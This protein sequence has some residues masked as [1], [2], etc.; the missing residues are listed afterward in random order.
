MC[1]STGAALSTT[2]TALW[3]H[4]VWLM[5]SGEFVLHD[6]WGPPSIFHLVH[7]R[8]AAARDHDDSVHLH[9]PSRRRWTR[10]CFSW[11]CRR[12][13]KIITEQRQALYNSRTNTIGPWDQ[14]LHY[15]GPL[16]STAVSKAYDYREYTEPI[17]NAW[18]HVPQMRYTRKT[19][20]Y[21]AKGNE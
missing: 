15:Q 17:R 6:G 21:P 18:W 9:L 10:I 8:R 3:A 19:G 1:K 11:S 16:E 12:V 7:R 14:Q 13:T 4:T 5:P 20:L 2:L